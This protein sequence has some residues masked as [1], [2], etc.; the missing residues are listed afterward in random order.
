MTAILVVNTITNLDPLLD[1]STNAFAFDVTGTL[2]PSSLGSLFTHCANFYNAVGTGGT[3][4]LAYYMGLSCD[5]GTN[6]CSQECYNITGHL[7]GTPHGSPIAA[8]TFTLGAKG[9]G[10]SYIPEGVAAAIS[11]RADYGTDVE[12]APGARPRARDRARIY[13]GPLNTLTLNGA[14]TT[15]R[16]IWISTFINDCLAALH[17]LSESVTIGTA[18]AVFKVWSRKDATLKLAVEGFMDDR[19]DYQRRRSDDSPGTRTF[20]PLAS[21]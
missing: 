4:A 20:L 12:F 6:H 19:P 9:S 3:H 2:D 15:N 14:S 8:S 1:A 5:R 17:D 13:L 10:S 16:C 11:Y 21:V 7:D 18:D